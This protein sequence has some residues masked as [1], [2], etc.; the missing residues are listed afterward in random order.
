MALVLAM[1]Y[2]EGRRGART[3]GDLAIGA[4]L[5][6]V[7]LLLILRQPDLGTAVTLIPVYLGVVFVAGMRLKWLAIQRCRRA[8]V[9][10]RLDVRA[11]GLP[12]GPGHDVPRSR[13]RTPRGKGLQQ[14]QAKVTVG[15]GGFSARASRRDRRA[16]YGFL[17]VAHN[18][19]V[20]SVLA[21]EQGFIGVLV[22]LGLYLFV[23][24]EEFGRR[25]PGQ[26]PGRRL[27]RRRN[28]LGFWVPSVVQHHYVGGSGPGQRP[29]AAA[30]ELWRVV[31][32][33]D[34]RRIW[35]HPQREDAAV[36]ELE[37]LLRC[38]VADERAGWNRTGRVAGGAVRRRVRARRPCGPS[39]GRRNAADAPE[40][41]A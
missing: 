14:I 17:P 16:R 34:P 8:A 10:G 20:F 11:E 23:L 22:T 41:Q 36:Y 40:L 12:E 31:A 13:R 38:R 25:Q 3:V 4:V 37:S 21:E 24:A 7:P 28:H 9:A 39:A 26:G 30:H 35:P 27:P 2:G 33:V 6:G 15:S 5:L 18:D 1:T 19:F 32:R 29:D